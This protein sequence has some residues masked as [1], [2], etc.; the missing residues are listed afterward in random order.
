MSPMHSFIEYLSMWQLALRALKSCTK[1]RDPFFFFTAKR[2]LL[3]QLW[4]SSMTPIFSHSLACFSTF[5][6]WVSGIWNCLSHHCGMAQNDA[7]WQWRDAF[8]QISI[9]VLLLWRHTRTAMNILLNEL[10]LLL[11]HRSL[12]LVLEVSFN[13]MECGNFLQVFR[14]NSLHLAI[15]H[16]HQ[17][18]N[19]L[20]S[21]QVD[22]C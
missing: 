14:V 15:R 18:A 20:I 2:G 4:V 21:F 6:W 3:Y 13:R 11:R 7:D 9:L 22:W 8:Y 17:V 5:S 12:L 16:I 19:Q 10:L 1:P